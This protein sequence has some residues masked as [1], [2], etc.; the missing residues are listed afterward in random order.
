MSTVWLLFRLNLK[1]GF[2]RET[3]G[4]L[5]INTVYLLPGAIF[6]LSF[7]LQNSASPDREQPPPSPPLLFLFCV[8]PPLVLLVLLL[9]LK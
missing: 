6:L 4:F 3:T 8:A 7:K 9:P 2:S 5:R 1:P